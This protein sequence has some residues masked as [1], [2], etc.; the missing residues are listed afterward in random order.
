MNRR[1]PTTLAILASTLAFSDTSSA[2]TADQFSAICDSAK[3]DCSEHPILQ[4]YVGGALDLLAVLDEETDYLR[5][6]YCVRPDR[7]FNVPAII[8]YIEEHEEAYAAKN[9]MLLVVRYL[10]ENGGC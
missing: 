6:V 9:A 8:R 10:E 7:L 1:I 5:S 2:L 4:A 3:V